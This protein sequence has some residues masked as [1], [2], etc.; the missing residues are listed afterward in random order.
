M[1]KGHED[2]IVRTAN[3]IEE[4]AARW[5]IRTDEQNRPE[6]WARLDAWLNEST[7]HRA[8]FLRL[9]VAW[10]RADALQKLAQLSGEI[11]EN[12]L[13]PA[14][15]PRAERSHT[16]ALVPPAPTH[17]S[18][19]SLTAANEQSTASPLPERFPQDDASGR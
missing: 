5:L 18:G 8:A 12:L 3:E 6:Q 19:L 2:K 11:D 9:S 14:R 10:R 13:D 7:R 4:E 1:T 17:H 15:W 16:E